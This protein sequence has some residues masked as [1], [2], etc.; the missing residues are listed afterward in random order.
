MIAGRLSGTAKTAF[1]ERGGAGHLAESST[2][3]NIM[4][5]AD[6]DDGVAPSVQNETV[7]S[8]QPRPRRDRTE[9]SDRDSAWTPLLNGLIYIGLFLGL[10]MLVFERLDF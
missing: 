10:S 4:L 3:V 1:A 2:P 9:N 7:E 8:E 5:V 6:T